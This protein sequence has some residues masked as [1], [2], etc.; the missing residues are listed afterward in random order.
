MN[1]RHFTR[2][3]FRVGASISYG[4]EV[5]ICN[6]YNMSL[7]GMYLTTEHEI[8]LNIPVHVTVYHTSLP[9]LMVHARVIRREHNGVGLEINNLNVTS[10]VQLRNL[11]TEYS[12]N[13]GAIMQET[14]KMLKCIS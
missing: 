14:Y 12:D 3:N 7:H 1:T 2:V 11:V 4:N 5:V 10:F 8:P 6:T 13:K 9:S